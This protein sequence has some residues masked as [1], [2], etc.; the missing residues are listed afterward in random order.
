M[1]IGYRHKLRL[2]ILLVLFSCAFFVNAQIDESEEY[3]LGCEYEMEIDGNAPTKARLLTRDYVVMPESYSLKQYCPIA[4]SQSRYG[5]CT[6]W[7]TTYAARTIC[8]AVANE[9]TNRDS[10][11]KEAFAP[12]F[13]YKQ[14]Q[15]IG[16]CQNGTS[17]AN[18]LDLL[19][20][21]GAP[22]FSSFNVL[23]SSYIPQ[24]LYSEALNYK[25]DGYSKLFDRK[26]NWTIS[27]W[28][29]LTPYETKIN[30]VKKA[31][32]QGHPVV[33]AMDVYPSFDIAKGCWSGELNGSK[34]GSHA[35]CVV[36]YDDSKYGGAFEIMNSWG[37]N[38]GNDGF[39]WIKYDDFFK[40]CMY[41]FDVYKKKT[42]PARKKYSFDGELD[43]LGKDGGTRMAVAFQDGK[44]PY[45]RASDGYLSGKK[46]RLYVSNNEPG[47]VYVLGSDLTNNVT[48][49]FPYSDNTSALLDYNQNNIAIPD[50]SHEFQFDNVA[51]TDYFCVLYSQ[52]ELDIDRVIKNIR[53]ASGSFYEKLIS[54]MG[55]KL[56]PK[57]DIVY[58]PDK[59]KVSGKSN[60]VVVPLVVEIN[61][62]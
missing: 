35:M 60:S 10:I 44:L 36:G 8:E 45:Y 26:Y 20:T 38:W 41:A 62:K 21:M 48:K 12:I 14:M 37:T 6:S 42:V 25:I 15:P 4:E 9:W 43:I 3:G 2:S 5:T 30:T 59:I 18:A 31:I 24:S 40:S 58:T 19:K 61:H 57:E 22:K 27:D 11:T 17:I 39:L 23:C 50:E 29:D 55:T 32:S 1:N 16:E 51:G 28:E 34:R 33:F 13:I 46:F 49:L 7:A 56:V 52:E 53:D 47:W 54:A